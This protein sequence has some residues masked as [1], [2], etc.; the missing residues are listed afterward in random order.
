MIDVESNTH[1][2]ALTN[3]GKF[4]E[5]SELGESSQWRHV[6]SKT[7]EDVTSNDHMVDLAE[8]PS[9]N[10][11]LGIAFYSFLGFTIVQTSYAIRAK[12]SAMVADSAAM[13]VDAGTYLC[14]MVA[15]RLK[16]RPLTQQ[17]SIMPP[18]LL[19]H[20]LK[21][22]R[23]YLELFPP[24]ISVVTLLYLTLTTFQSAIETLTTYE[25]IGNDEDE[26]GPD[27]KVMMFFSFL[28]LLLDIVNVTCF[29]RVHQAVMTPVNFDTKTEKSPLLPIDE[30]VATGDETNLDDEEI[31][32]DTLI[33]L[34]MCSAWT[35]SYVILLIAM[36]SFLV[37]RKLIFF[38][39]VFNSMCLQIQCDLYLF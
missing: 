26:E 9:N 32:N 15:E 3:N 14:N 24:L 1:A 30:T 16:T 7:N 5:E 37:N 34:N 23:L 31:S 2:K 8:G 20:K 12:S 11:V 38:T 25:P 6:A 33:N 36:F 29:A 27:V 21:L 28:N 17:E 4:S 35:V 18:C 39:F 10:D 22:Q 19:E 13:F